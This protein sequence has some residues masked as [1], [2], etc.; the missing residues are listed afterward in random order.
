M[1]VAL[2]LT[3]S[4]VFYVPNKYTIHAEQDCIN[5]LKNKKILKFCILIVIKITNNGDIINSSPCE[6]CC[7]IIKKYKVRK[8]ISS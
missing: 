6:N 4:P 7:R 2:V 5:N 8:I 1:V 3:T